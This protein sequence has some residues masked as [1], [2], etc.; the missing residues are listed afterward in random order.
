M[1][2]ILVKHGP[3]LTAVTMMVYHFDWVMELAPH[4]S[5]HL[6]FTEPSTELHVYLCL[7]VQVMQHSDV[8]LQLAVG[9]PLSQLTV[10][11]TAV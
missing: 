5:S 3:F 1:G 9:V 11:R 8:T 10:V 6:K 4:V 2:L 7:C